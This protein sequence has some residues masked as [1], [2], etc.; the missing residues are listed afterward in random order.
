MNDVAVTTS[1]RENGRVSGSASLTFSLRKAADKWATISTKI[2]P[3]AADPKNGC[4][5]LVLNEL[6]KTCSQAWNKLKQ[7]SR[8]TPCQNGSH[9]NILLFAFKFALRTSFL[10]EIKNQ[11]NILP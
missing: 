9:L 2:V 5:G 1:W 6:S 7:H 10:T 3:H 4:V 11:K 8:W